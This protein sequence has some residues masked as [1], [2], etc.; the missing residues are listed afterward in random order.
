MTQIIE[1][2]KQKI[3]E[4]DKDANWWAMQIEGSDLNP[5]HK[6]ELLIWLFPPINQDALVVGGDIDDMG[7]F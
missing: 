7:R 1:N 6:E 2:L 4:S 3:R 5:A